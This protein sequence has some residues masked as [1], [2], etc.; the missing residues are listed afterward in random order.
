M[1]SEQAARRYL[2]IFI[3]EIYRKGKKDMAMTQKKMDKIVKRDKRRKRAQGFGATLGVATSFLLIDL[4]LQAK[5]KFKK[6]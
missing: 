5:K 1:Q 4:Y 3:L 2:K 6:G